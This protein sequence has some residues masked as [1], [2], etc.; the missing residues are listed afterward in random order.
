MDSQSVPS[1]ATD[2][3]FEAVLAAYR[4]TLNN[5]EITGEDDFFESGGDSVQ[6]MKATEL[7][8]EK[9]GIEVSLGLFF[10]YPTAAELA[11]A[12]AAGTD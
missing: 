4:Q 10:T 7:I 3:V 2:N 12:L 8:L 5:T 1:I 6:V 9:T 11:T